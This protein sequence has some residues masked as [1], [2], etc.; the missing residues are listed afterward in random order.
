MKILWIIGL[1]LLAALAGLL[2][3]IAVDV[4]L[5]AFTPESLLDKPD[6]VPGIWLTGQAASPWCYG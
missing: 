1:C 6:Y 2:L 3:G 4:A 5:I